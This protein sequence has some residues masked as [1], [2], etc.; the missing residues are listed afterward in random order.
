MP[1][2]SEMLPSKFLKKED[3][4]SPVL[5]TIA[6]VSHELVEQ[7]TGEMKW[8]MHFLES[9]NNT[10]KPMVLNSTNIQLCE[11]ILGSDDTD[12]WIGKKIVV[13][14]DPTIMFGGKVVGGLRVRAVAGRAAK[15]TQAPAAPPAPPAVLADDPGV[16]GLADDGLPY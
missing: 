5:V 7:D 8:A 1:K 14:T 13:Y 16:A 6:A 15:A 4:P 10:S 3:V 11:A 2:V 12:Q 9:I